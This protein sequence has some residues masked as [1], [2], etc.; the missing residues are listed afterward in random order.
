M[1]KTGS[2][3][4]FIRCYR[5]SSLSRHPKGLEKLDIYG[6]V[7]G[8]QI[9]GTKRSFAYISKW[10]PSWIL[11]FSDKIIIKQILPLDSA[12]KNTLIR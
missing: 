3:Y 2:M 4:Q 8:E 10:P 11:Q 5:M 9:A 1:T 6:W 7:A 12:Y